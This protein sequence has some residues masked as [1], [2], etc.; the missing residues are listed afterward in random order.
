[1]FAAT[2]PA[3][4]PIVNLLIQQ[5]K[6]RDWLVV[7]LMV[8]TIV[9]SYMQNAEYHAEDEHQAAAHPPSI[10]TQALNPSDITQL[11]QRIER[12]LE[13][14]QA[15]A[16]QHGRPAHLKRKQPKRYGKTKRKRHR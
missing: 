7:L 15:P 8:L 12:R 3:A 13:A 6:G 9:I 14:P 10:T 2:N 4:A 16:V 1:V 5:G 11:Q